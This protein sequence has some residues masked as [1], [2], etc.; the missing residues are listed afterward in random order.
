MTKSNLRLKSLLISFRKCAIITKNVE[1]LILIIETLEKYF[2]I[3]KIERGTRLKL[4]KNRC[5]QTTKKR[6]KGNFD[7]GNFFSSIRVPINHERNDDPTKTT[8]HRV[9]D[10][11]RSQ[12]Q[13]KNVTEAKI[14]VGS[15]LNLFLTP[16]VK[17][18]KKRQR[19]WWKR[20]GK[21]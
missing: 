16:P 15:I 5:R 13:Q 14:I 7:D 3:G 6:Q 1:E 12:Y 10:K 21:N 4:K 11:K 8:K 19:F 20:S 17:I 2:A 9:R 18:N